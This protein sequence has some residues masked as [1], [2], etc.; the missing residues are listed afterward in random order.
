[1]DPNDTQSFQVPETDDRPSP[2]D[3]EVVEPRYFG[4]T[5]TSLV[6]TLAAAL[7]LFA[8]VSFVAISVLVGFL[9]LLAALL[10]GALF[11]EQARH[12]RGTVVER[13]TAY[14]LDQS[15]GLAGYAGVSMRAWSSAGRQVTALRLE[16][17]LLRRRRSRLQYALGGAVHGGDEEEADRLRSR[18]QEVDDRLS[19]VGR[20]I[21]RALGQARRRT[22]RERLAV[23]STEIRRP[24]SPGG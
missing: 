8:L 18:M 2:V 23:A 17:R 16:A 10:F 22:S 13:A 5:P 9:F 12:R 14:A 15:K 7:L 24:H 6:A 20:E 11:A 1:M 19:R 21:A 3:Y 4:L